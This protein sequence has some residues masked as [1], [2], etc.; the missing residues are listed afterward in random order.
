MNLETPR[1]GL[2]VVAGLLAVLAV[3]AGPNEGTAVPLAGGA[4]VVAS[5]VV[6]LSLVRQV[7]FRRRPIGPTE[8]HSL[9]A[10]RQAF[11]EGPI[12]RQRIAQALL[13]LERESLGR[14]PARE[15][16]SI[17][18]HPETADPKEFRAWV[19]ER[20]DELEGAS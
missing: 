19:R 3:V 11:R 8:S 9:V 17:A 10:L 5:V 15:A 13:E 7:R 2:L 4:L 20:L 1:V 14:V 6:V 16:G 12:G 18:L